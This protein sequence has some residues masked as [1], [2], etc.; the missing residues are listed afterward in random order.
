MV[1]R[2]DTCSDVIS[3][4]IAPDGPKTDPLAPSVQLVFVKGNGR[5]PVAE[6]SVKRARRTQDRGQVFNEWDPQ[7]GKEGLF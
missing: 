7:G 5:R 1:S 2:S 3:R 4:G 6:A